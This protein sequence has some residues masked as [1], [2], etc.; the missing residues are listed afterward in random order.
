[1]IQK[2]NTR[3]QYPT[4]GF[5]ALGMSGVPLLLSSEQDI[6]PD[7]YPQRYPLATVNHKA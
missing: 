3:F 4:K 2:K 7:Y 6:Q 1:M 5:D